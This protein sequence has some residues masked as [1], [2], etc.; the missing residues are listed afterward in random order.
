[1][2]NREFTTSKRRQE[3]NLD[4]GHEVVV[5]ALEAFMRFLLDNNDDI[6]WNNAGRLIAFS[7]EGDCLAALHTLVDV[8]LEHL[9]LRNHLARVA[10]LALVT[11]IDDLAS[12]RTLVAWL[13]QLL[14]H[15][16]HLAKRD[17]DATTL[18]VTAWPHSALLPAFAI[19]LSTDNVA[20]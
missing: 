19:A 11:M 18:T 12:S 7:S 20:C 13:L 15:G 3:L 14:D 1:V 6:A 5:V 4:V 8:Y 9:L 17:S 2:L 16:S 10:T